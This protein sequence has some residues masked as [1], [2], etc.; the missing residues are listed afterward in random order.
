MKKQ[1]SIVLAALVIVFVITAGLAIFA[2]KSAP[3]A[4]VRV[5]DFFPYG[6]YIGGG[7]WFD[8]EQTARDG[9][10]SSVAAYLENLN[11]LIEKGGFNVVWPNNLPADNE[12]EQVLR[13]WLDSAGRHGI[14][15]IP[16]GGVFPGGTEEIYRSV[17]NWPNLVNQSINPF[18]GQMVPKFRD[19]PSLLLWSIGE[20][21]P[22]EENDRPIYEAIKSVADFVATMD[23][24]HPAT[25]LYH[26]TDGVIMAAQIVRP[27]IMISNIG[28]FSDS[29]GLVT[30]TQNTI[31][32]SLEIEKRFQE[33]RAIGVPFWVMGSASE[34]DEYEN[35]VLLVD[36]RMQ[37][38]SEIR[39]QFW[40]A[41]FHGAKG[42]FYFV[43]RDLDLAPGY[44]GEYI[45]G[46]VDTYNRPRDM[47]DAAENLGKETRALWSLLPR[48]DADQ[49]LYNYS[50]YSIYPTESYQ[51]YW[52]NLPKVRWR[53]FT[54]RD[55][56]GKYWMAV[57]F[58]LDNSRFVAPPPGLSSSARLKNV[59]SGAIYDYSGISGISLS[60]GSGVLFE[61]L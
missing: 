45:R 36:R 28:A 52:E 53:S 15:V 50:D 58:D 10:F 24:D 55:S 19:D 2:F 1:K 35:G 8:L 43:F 29:P 9:G 60:P 11:S 41:I 3:T 25:F 56:G 34:V 42:Y 26:W 32:Y 40:S 33:A 59:V 6:V 4:I 47:F 30:W 48:L 5:E 51:E 18:Y 39:W 7:T 17:D 16:Q 20:E 14:K 38:P 12:Y 22:A 27:R 57:N 46:M 61:S 54:S 44:N 31:Y 49:L 37:R 23:N 21:P 13:V